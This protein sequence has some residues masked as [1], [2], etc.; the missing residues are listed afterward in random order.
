MK[1]LSL[2][3]IK[4]VELDILKQFDDFCSKHTLRYYL[5]GGTL[6]GAIRHK[7]FIP[8]DDD[9]DVAML[10]ADFDKL[11]D[12]IKNDSRFAI[13]PYYRTDTQVFI[14]KMQF[15]DSDCPFWI[16]ILPYD[17]VRAKGKEKEVWRKIEEIRSKLHSDKLNISS[18]LS[19][20]YNDN[21]I[22]N[23]DDLRMFN[24]LFEESYLQ[25]PDSTLPDCM[26]RGIDT[27]FFGGEKLIY[28]DDA[29]PLI[30][31]EFEGEKYWAFKCYHDY[32]VGAYGDYMRFPR[33]LMPTHSSF[34]EEKCYEIDDYIRQIKEM[35]EKNNL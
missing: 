28:L 4:K 23:E 1:K 10:R 13:R 11:V 21:W 25:L 33:S 9:I 15:A 29:F 6:L 14:I 34:Y 35:E 17:L 24:H 5:A 32:L 8:W 27:M 18:K 12:I 3:E 22:Q 30:R 31:V 26:Y 19:R 20:Y 16:D 7:G 2:N